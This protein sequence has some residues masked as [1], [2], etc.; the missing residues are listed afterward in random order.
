[1]GKSKR[2]SQSRV[3]GRGSDV[4]DCP[5]GIQ[6]AVWIR[7]QQLV[8]SKISAVHMELNSKVSQLEK[9]ERDNQL[10]RAK[11]SRLEI[12]HTRLRNEVRGVKQ[13]SMKNN[14]IFNFD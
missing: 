1:M 14:L 10:L 3:E 6:E 13:H 9:A 11:L 2:A 8:D 4:D 5:E 7:I 12:S